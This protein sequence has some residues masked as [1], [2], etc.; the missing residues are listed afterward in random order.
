MR[1]IITAMVAI[2]LPTNG[3]LAFRS[4]TV[5]VVL[6]KAHDVTQR[7]LTLEVIKAWEE[8]GATY[9]RINQNELGYYFEAD[10]P[11]EGDL[12][13]FE[14]RGDLQLSKLPAPD[15]QFGLVYS[16]VSDADLKELTTLKYLKALIVAYS[17]VTDAGVKEIAKLKQLQMLDL[18]H[19]HVTD[20]GIKELAALKQLR[21]LDLNLTGVTDMGLEELNN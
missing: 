10:P 12:P 4:T 8:A 5:S 13:F 11:K 14:V 19:T 9:G 15:V 16:H 3:T 18:G 20:T 6:R 2:L 1:V 17:G 7:Q 21:T